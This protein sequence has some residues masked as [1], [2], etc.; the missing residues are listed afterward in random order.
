M[1]GELDKLLAK[2]A[3]AFTHPKIAQRVRQLAYGNLTCLGRHTISGMITASGRQFMD[4]SAAYRLF[5]EQRI[6]VAKL[7]QVCLER[8]VEEVAADQ[9]IVAHMDDTILKKT[10]KKIPGT[11]WRRDPLGPPF[12]TNFIW[13]QRFIQLSMSI[14]ERQ[15]PSQSRAI[16]IGMYHC[17]TPK[18]PVRTATE[19]EIQTYKEVKKQSRLSVQGSLQIK[20]LREKLDEQDH[21]DR[22]LCMGVDGSYTNSTVLKNL[23][24]RTVL[25]GRIRKDAKLYKTADPSLGGKGRKKVYG[26]QLPTPEQIRQSADYPWQQVEAWAAGK[27]HTFDIKVVKDIKSRTAG[28]H[29]L[30]QLIVVRPLAYRL[31]KSSK[32][33]YRKPAYLICTDNTMDAQTLLQHYLWRWE[34]E[35]NIR[36]EK[37]LMGCGQAQVRNEH[38]AAD[39]PAFVSAMYAFLLLAHIRAFKK[40]GEDKNRDLILPR[41][42]WYPA[43]KEQRFTTGDLINHLRTELWAKAIGCGNFSSFVKQHHQTKSQRNTT[44]HMTGAL[45]YSRK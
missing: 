9:M 11:S 14:P 15:G 1:T 7:Q 18:K 30:L 20:A 28:Q 31:N 26:D 22:T 5:S 17:P 39:V 16:P 4:W 21:Q 25:I 33:L 13:G 38:S 41:P 34:I 19:E 45:F 23:P 37:T 40:N 10:G 42:K 29:H 12:H 27:K 8:A 3:G 43:K 36:D 32:L 2:G 6:D 35:V 24:E 44:N